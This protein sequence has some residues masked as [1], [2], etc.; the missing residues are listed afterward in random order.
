MLSYDATLV[1]Q[2]TNLLQIFSHTVALFATELQNICSLFK[3][4][5][6]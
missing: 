3:M 6:T 2:L 4:K 1:C 5:I